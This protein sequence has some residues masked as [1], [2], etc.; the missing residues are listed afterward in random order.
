MMGYKYSKFSVTGSKRIVNQDAIDIVE[1]ENGLLFILC[2]GMGGEGIN[3]S[4]SELAIKTIKAFF[5][6]DTGEDYLDRLK[7]AVIE[8]NDFIYNRSNGKNVKNKQASTIELLYLKANTAYIAHVGDSRIYHLKNGHLKQL[9]K[10]HSLIQKLVDEGFLT[11]KEAEN[12]PEKNVVLKAIGD[13][14][15]IDAD[16]MKVKLNKFDNNKFFI[17]SDGVINILSNDQISSLLKN[18][19]CESIVETVKDILSNTGT[20]DDFSFIYI[21]DV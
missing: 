7:T 8:A 21:E 3:E 1:I 15:L 12:H 4:A 5:E 9:T 18:N 16:L 10:D 6:N 13:K 19:N 14:G 17:C 20:D 11:Y 2:D